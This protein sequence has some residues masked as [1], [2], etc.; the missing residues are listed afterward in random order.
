MAQTKR[1]TPIIHTLILRVSP[2]VNP[3]EMS[4]EYIEE[5]GKCKIIFAYFMVDSSCN[6]IVLSKFMLLD[7]GTYQS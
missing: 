1:D 7:E 2:A 4:N 5:P 3:L 6:A